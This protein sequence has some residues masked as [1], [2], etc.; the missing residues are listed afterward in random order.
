ME[1]EEGGGSGGDGEEDEDEEEEGL[2]L[3][4]E[5]EEDEDDDD[6]EE[7]IP[8]PSEAELRR[9]LTLL[10]TMSSVASVDEAGRLLE[11][12]MV[13][14]AGGRYEEALGLLDEALG[15]AGAETCERAEALVQVQAAKVKGTVLQEMGLPREAS[16]WF[17]LCARAGTRVLQL[18]PAEEDLGERF[19]PLRYAHKQLAQAYLSAQAYALVVEHFEHLLALTDDPAERRLLFRDFERL[20]LEFDFWRVGGWVCVCVSF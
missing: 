17:E 8:E 7:G 12:A 5:E 1:T 13:V 2:E 6:D 19:P 10:H 14:V 3:E 16:L 9:R 20:S 4:E 11:R 18:T 15:V